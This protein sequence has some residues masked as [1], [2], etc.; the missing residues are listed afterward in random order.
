MLNF[1][2]HSALIIWKIM[3]WMSGLPCRTVEHWAH[4][5][6][7][8]P[9]SCND[10]AMWG[11]ILFDNPVV[12]RLVIKSRAFF[13]TRRFIP[14]FTK[15]FHCVLLRWFS[16]HRN[17]LFV[18]SILI[19]SAHPCVHAHVLFTW[20]CWL[21]VFVFIFFLMRSTF[22]AHP[23]FLISLVNYF[24]LMEWQTST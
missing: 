19:L 13:R 2:V 5:E 4:V 3:N 14:V 23:Y 20:S 6:W 16:T 1:L 7:K 12:V 22:P 11:R 8:C 21:N 15:A 10:T 18:R 17:T 9:S 24:I